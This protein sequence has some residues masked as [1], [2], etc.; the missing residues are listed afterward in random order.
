MRTGAA[1]SLANESG[2]GRASHGAN[3]ERSRARRGPSKPLSLQWPPSVNSLLS[4][5]AL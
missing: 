2:S 1:V 4:L 5:A 3:A